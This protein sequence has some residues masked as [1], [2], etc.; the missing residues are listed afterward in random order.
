LNSNENAQR[1]L[2]TILKELTR[3]AF[4][5][6]DM[7]QIEP[8]VIDNIALP[9]AAHFKDAPPRAKDGALLLDADQWRIIQQTVSGFPTDDLGMKVRDAYQK[10]IDTGRIRPHSGSKRSR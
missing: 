2:N 4:S 1:N 8:E 9:D 6:Q 10:A 5:A 7:K 3:G